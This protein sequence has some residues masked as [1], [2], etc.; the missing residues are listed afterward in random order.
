MQYLKY[1][2]RDSGTVLV[3]VDT[4]AYANNDVASDTTRGASLTFLKSFSQVWFTPV[5]DT[6]QMTSSLALRC[7]GFDR[8]ITTFLSA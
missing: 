4:D 6:L 1:E 8:Q 2:S 5:R 3:G 7:L